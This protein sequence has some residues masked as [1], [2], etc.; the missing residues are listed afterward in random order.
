MRWPLILMAFLGL[1]MCQRDETV[2][3]HGGGAAEWNLVS[4]DGAAFEAR[5][6]VEFPEEGA[7]AGKGPCNSYR[8]EQ[9]A[10][11]PWFDADRI[12]VTRQACPE[13]EA[14]ARFLEMLTAMTQVEVAGGILILSND[15]GREMV[16]RASD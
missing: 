15:A 1:D 16:F 3:G 7:I 9:T 8:G 14:E 10:P 5:A 11:Y 12:S 2:S 6:T 4:I 13:L